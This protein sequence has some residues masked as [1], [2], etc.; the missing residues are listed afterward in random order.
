MARGKKSDMFM[1]SEIVYTAKL[2]HE[3]NNEF[4]I[5]S[6]SVDRS[7]LIQKLLLVDFENSL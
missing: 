7:K 3:S 5:Q 4:D 1:K 6:H 2:L